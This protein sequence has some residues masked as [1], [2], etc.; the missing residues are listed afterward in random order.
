MQMIR[1]AVG[2]TIN[3]GGVNVVVYGAPG[4]DVAELADIIADRINAQVASRKAVFA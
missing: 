3:Y 2:D 4:Q 1:S